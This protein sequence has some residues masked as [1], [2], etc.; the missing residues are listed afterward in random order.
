MMKAIRVPG[1]AGEIVGEIGLADRGSCAGET[2][3]AD[4]NANAEFLPRENV[5]DRG[6]DH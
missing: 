3:G 2:D 6:A 1:I 4:Q 5:L